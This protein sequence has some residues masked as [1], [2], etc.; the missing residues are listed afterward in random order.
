M[1]KTLVI[2]FL[3][4]LLV[5]GVALLVWT[6]VDAHQRQ[7]NNQPRRKYWFA[8]LMAAMIGILFPIRFVLSTPASV[9]LLSLTYVA[10]PSDVGGA[11][12]K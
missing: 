2:S 3:V 5:A 1:L 6:I 9:I 11:K 4:I 8:C 10:F 12:V 7:R